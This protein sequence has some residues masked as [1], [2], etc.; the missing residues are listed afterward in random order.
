MGIPVTADQLTDSAVGRAVGKFARALPFSGGH[1]IEEEQRRQ[2]TRNVTST[3][4]PAEDDAVKAVG[5]AKRELGSQFDDISG[6]N[7]LTMTNS[8][9]QKVLQVAED[10]AARGGSAHGELEK[11]AQNVVKQH[12]DVHEGLTPGEIYQDWRSTAGKNQMSA[13]AG[14]VNADSWNQ[15]QKTLDDAMRRSLGPAEANDWDFL[16]YQYGNMKDV[17][18][19]LPVKGEGFTSG[20]LDPEKVAARMAAPTAKN[21][22]NATA[23]QQGANSGD[24][25]ADAAQVGNAFVPRPPA[26]DAS[27]HAIP[28]ASI[29]KAFGPQ[30]AGV[31][32]G[33]A[34][35]Y[36]ISHL[37]PEDS[38][39]HKNPLYA[40]LAG[41][42]AS[43]AM[44]AT[45]GRYLLSNAYKKGLPATVNL[46]EGI[47][48]K[49][50]RGSSALPTIMRT[51]NAAS[52][53]TQSK[54]GPADK[55][56]FSGLQEVPEEDLGTASAGPKEVPPEDQ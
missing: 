35:G 29:L 49:G 38:A 1:A 43:S 36:G 10:N 34:S 8:D 18:K 39:L 5:N 12:T 32:G 55:S 23:M 54:A 7:M 13:G 48:D 14:S 2:L 52:G 26:A 53:P 56:P 3:F 46:L 15:M 30:V 41:A 27:G 4:G 47:G 11:F 24:P 51:A 44:G 37:A 33:A 25:L 42:G 50:V 21:G 22:A 6:N 9:I 40:A 19:M 45:L 17:E 20:T 28:G 31:A 16:R